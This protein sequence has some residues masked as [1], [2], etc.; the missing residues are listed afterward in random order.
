MAV[1]SYMD[2]MPMP[3]PIACPAERF[4][5]AKC[6]EKT[7][8]VRIARGGLVFL[9][10]MCGHH[11]V[12]AVICSTGKAKYFRWAKTD[13]EKSLMK[14]GRGNKRAKC[15]EECCT[16]C[17]AKMHAHCDNWLCKKC[18]DKLGYNCTADKHTSEQARPEFPLSRIKD[19][20]WRG[21]DAEEPARDAREIIDVDAGP[22]VIVI[23]DD[24]HDSHNGD[25][26]SHDDED[27]C[28]S[29]A[30]ED[31]IARAIR[32]SLLDADEDLRAL[33]DEEE[34][35]AHAIRLSL[36]SAHSPAAQ[37]DDDDDDD[38]DD[39]Y[40]EDGDLSRA[41]KLSRW[42]LACM[43]SNGAGPSRL[44]GKGGASD[45]I[46]VKVS[47]EHLWLLSS[48]AHAV[49]SSQQLTAFNTQANAVRESGDAIYRTVVTVPASR[50]EQGEFFESDFTDA[51]LADLRLN[52]KLLK[53][54][55]VWDDNFEKYLLAYPD[56]DDD[57]ADP[58]FACEVKY[59][60]ERR[61]QFLTNTAL[62]DLGDHL[63]L[64]EEEQ[65]RDERR[66]EDSLRPVLIRVEVHHY[67]K[68]GLCQGNMVIGLGDCYTRRRRFYLEDCMVS[69]N[70]LSE[71]DR[72]ALDLDDVDLSV[73]DDG[74]YRPGGITMDTLLNA[75]PWTSDT[76]D[77]EL[78]LILRVHGSPFACAKKRKAIRGSGREKG[79][80]KGKEKEETGDYKRRKVA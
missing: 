64:T 33:R 62:E 19:D 9:I 22:E 6:G 74:D 1:V 12:V 60:T 68:K 36:L 71:H 16:H 23:D 28:A 59:S 39:L 35:L 20:V 10:A 72:K 69:L 78:K 77:H 44:Q 46:K 25:E 56:E 3:K 2:G 75:V 8:W 58:C 31:D 7:R 79:K 73:T 66:D 42:V 41:L 37:Q 57:P 43:P 18:C 70:D 15:V 34:E 54:L 11:R 51:A 80:G 63:E 5:T 65:R 32:L 14:V 17:P 50:G 61:M 49:A 47:C 30:D 27:S 38:D 45:V 55:R 4:D 67:E 76:D 24:S 29:R 21:D 48:R 53:K 26:D 13:F 40:V 52:R